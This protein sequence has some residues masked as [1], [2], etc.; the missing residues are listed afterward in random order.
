MTTQTGLRRTGPPSGAWTQATFDDL[1]DSLHTTTFVIVDLETTGGSAQADR[2]TEIGA[3]KVRG[4][5]VLGEFQTLVHPGQPIPAFI[6]VL[7][8]ITD[9]MVA[10]APRIEVAL[11]AFLS[12]AGDAVLVAHNARFD[13]SFLKAA[14]AAAEIPW[15]EVPVIDT[16]HLARQLVTRDEAPNCK[17]STLAGLFSATT[18]P[19]HRALHDAR[20]TVDVLHALIGRVGNLGVSTLQELQSF[21]ARVRPEQR[22]KRYLADDLPHVAGV[23]LFRDA[24]AKVLYVGVSTDIRRRVL[25]YFTS[26]ERRTRMAEMVSIAEAVD[27]VPCATDLEARVRELRL[28]AEYDPPYNRRSRRPSRQPWIKLTAEPFPRLSV[29]RSVRPDGATYAGPFASAV[30]AREAVAALHEALHLRQCTSTLPRHPRG[31]GCLLGDVGKCGAPCRGDQS[32]E[33]YAK[34]A[35]QAVEMLA[36]DGRTVIDVLDARLRTLASAERYED[37]V[38]TRDRAAQLVSGAAR[39]QRVGP[40]A[41]ISELVAAR[42]LAT[43]GWE[44]ICVRHGR[45]AGTTRTPRGADPMPHIDGLR[46]AAEVVAAPVAPA[47]AASPAESDLI[48]S[49]L[50]LPGTRLVHLDGSWTCPVGGAEG[51]LRRFRPSEDALRVDPHL[52]DGRQIRTRHQPAAALRMP[53]GAVHQ[54]EEGRHPVDGGR[55]GRLAVS[56]PAPSAREE[57]YRG[58]VDA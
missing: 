53:E 57:A 32:L 54:S 2:I 8:G 6:S 36:G 21:T 56:R 42:R 52:W 43:G 35:A 46:G 38:T 18:S 17:L 50:D 10:T 41:A 26:S 1:G 24:R 47:P 23:Y 33:D 37:A 45:L 27:A 58:T 20:A 4:G 15:R 19:D 22:R 9:A 48:L 7:T 28:I 39:S 30:A 34:I 51:A 29:V 12:F 40:I 25:T 44:V 49:W 13:I 31:G 55:A 16:C 11:P 5:E 14:S 3:V